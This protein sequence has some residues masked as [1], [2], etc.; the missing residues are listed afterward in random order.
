MYKRKP[1][2]PIEVTSSSLSTENDGAEVAA[3][4]IDEYMKSMMEWTKNIHEN[5]KGNINEAQKKQKKYF[6]AKH[7]PPTFKVRNVSLLFYALWIYLG[8]R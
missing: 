2:L 4:Q 5:A 6:D 7:R 1:R 3:N 8:W